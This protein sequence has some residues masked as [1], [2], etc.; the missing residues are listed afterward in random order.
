MMSAKTAVERIVSLIFSLD[1]FIYYTRTHPRN[2][3]ID[4]KVMLSYRLALFPEGGR[5]VVL[6]QEDTP[7]MELEDNC[8]AEM[9]YVTEFP[10][11]SW[12]PP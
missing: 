6:D 9:L 7:R 2:F 3:D 12:T 10:H 5:V 1:K 8:G 11:K 4:Q